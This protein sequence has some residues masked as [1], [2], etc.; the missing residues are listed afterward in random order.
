MLNR[1][2][3][4]GAVL[5]LLFFVLGPG[6]AGAQEGVDE[7]LEELQGMLGGGGSGTTAEQVD[8]LVKAELPGVE[9]AS[10]M[11]ASRPITTHLVS[12]EEAHAHVLRVMAEQLPP[13]RLAPMEHA[14]KAMGL[15]P[16]DGSL[17]EAVAD[18]YSGQAGGFYDPAAERLVL[19]SD[20]P[21]ML[22][23][24]VVR[25]ELVH[26]LQDQV[27][28][29]ERWIGDAAEDEDRAAAIQAVLEGHATDVM[30]RTTMSAMGLEELMADP[31]M[32]AA[33]EGLFDDSGDGGATLLDPSEQAG[34]MASMLPRG[35]PPALAAQLLFPYLTGAAFVS[36][37]R[38]A[39][40]EDPG[41]EAL[42]T[43]PPQTTAEVLE[44]A[45]WEAGFRASLREPGTLVPGFETVY[46]STL[47]RLL[48][49][50]LLTGQG[51]PSAGDPQAATWN[52]PN[53]DN[54]VAVG[55]GW[56]GDHVV[57]AKNT[58]AEPG[59]GAPDPLA[60]AWASDWSSAAEAEAVAARLAER[61]PGAT[62]DVQGGRLHVVFDAGGVAPEAWIRALRTWQ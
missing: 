54:S 9:A 31:D 29:L 11:K 60:V 23:A 50:V 13:E 35:T 15:L 24:P 27:H 2:S 5:A 53:R 16:R 19:L 28:D 7:I 3:T 6:F 33:L 46:D 36:G 34:L 55:G 48:A 38:E 14:W 44:P 20:L 39:H 37:Y 57:V 10:G 26:A 12:R 41:C 4:G 30:N 61:V 25:H 62:I 56:R 40:P 22:Q 43:R 17:G 18:L 58:R 32:A 47:G 51:D 45:L 8:A 52:R 42:Y 49:A 59:T 1:L 21:S